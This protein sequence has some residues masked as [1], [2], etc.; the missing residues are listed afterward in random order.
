MKLYLFAIC[1]VMLFFSF[2]LVLSKLRNLLD[3]RDKMK[4]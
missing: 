1:T 3:R 4:I 2:F